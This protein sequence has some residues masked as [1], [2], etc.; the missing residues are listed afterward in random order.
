MFGVVGGVLVV[1]SILFL[2]KLKIDDLV[3]VILVYGICGLL[4]LLL[5]FLIN[6]D[7]LFLG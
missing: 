2:D 3:G 4:G 6:S 1:F 7:V 5:V